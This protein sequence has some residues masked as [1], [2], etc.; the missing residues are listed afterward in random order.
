MDSTITLRNYLEKRKTFIVPDY[1]RGYVWGK[2]KSNPK[3]L[4]SVTYI[5]NTIF[6]KM[7]AG[8]PIF[9]QGVTVTE[10]KT[11][12]VLI[13]GQQR[14]TFL[15]ILLKILGYDG[16]IHIRYAIRKESDDFLRELSTDADF[17]NNPHEEFQDIY[18]FKKSARMIIERLSKGNIDKPRILKYL[19]DNIK[20]LYINIH[21]NQ[22]RKVF[23]MMNG[24]RAK[25]LEP[26]II[27]AELLR[28]VSLSSE[29][30]TTSDEWE[31][32]MLRS[33]YAREWDKWL[34][35]WNRD[36]V[37]KM[38][39]TTWQLGWLLI[40]MMPDGFSNPESVTFESFCRKYLRSADKTDI[41]PLIKKAKDTFYEL[42]QT[43]KR[44]EDTFN[45]DILH[46]KIG[47][48]LRVSNEPA[49]FIKYYFQGEP[50]GHDELDKYYLC[51]FLSMTHSNIVAN[52]DTFS[53]NFREKFDKT[54]A[55][56]KSSNI[57][58][59][60][61]SKEVAFKQLLR[62]N[63]DEDNRQNKGSGRKFDFTIWDDGVR[64]LEHIYAK[65]NVV[66]EDGNGNWLDGNNNPGNPDNSLKRDEIGYIDNTFE[67]LSK[68]NLEES[69]T[70]KA[71]EHCIGNL[72]LLYSDD[73]STF[74][75]NDFDKKKDIFLVGYDDKETKR[76]EFFKSRHLI[77][78]VCHFAESKWGPDEIRKYFTGTLNEFVETYNPIIK[79][80]STPV[81]NA[82]QD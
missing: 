67:P 49:K 74:N 70:L 26:E 39:K 20:F 17:S 27:K 78:T 60:K 37:R 9:L 12:I 22:A 3:D 14:T 5:L 7:A 50:V 19:L 32:N 18:Y 42:R 41:R 62:L 53:E 21:E 55:I 29:A 65:S 36:E 82:E 76:K 34:H 79:A 35:W 24:Q 51:S 59:D 11:E 73:N 81:K 77:H 45:C 33:R 47:A 1:Q 40:A 69:P 43:Q 44:F 31:F 58:E 48:I 66:H 75:A 54:L 46:N 16:D 13:D 61:E 80:L 30:T 8:D 63:I 28:L 25:M 68:A 10:N 52:K 6:E 56:L 4:D 15:Y 64:S 72:V 57:Y 23:T 38:Y 71:T 2:K